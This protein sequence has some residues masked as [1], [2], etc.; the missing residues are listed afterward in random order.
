[1]LVVGAGAA[2]AVAA[3]EIARR[4]RSVVHLEEPAAAAEAAGL[5]LGTIPTGLLL[6]YSR[7]VARWGRTEAAAIWQVHREGHERLRELLAWLGRDCAYRNSGGFLLA[8]S[9][10][11]GAALAGSEDLLREDG[12]PGE[13]L[14]HYM[15]EARFDVEGFAAA[16]WSA[17]EGD[18][19]P[20]AFGRA[21]ADAVGNVARVQSGSAILE[22]ELSSRG[23]RAVTERGTV[24]AAA[25]VLAL[26]SGALRLVPGLP[27][28]L[29]V[30][31]AWRVDSRLPEGPSLPAMARVLDRGWGWRCV[32]QEVQ[33]AACGDGEPSNLSAHVAAPLDALCRWDGKVVLGPDGFPLVGLLPGRPAALVAGLADMGHAYTVTAARWAAEALVTGFDPT[34]ERFR[35]ARAWKN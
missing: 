6:P 30:V 23:V 17:D 7:A 26:D 14:D 24:A 15:F 29:R 20:R 34:P 35:A 28:R 25:A 33:A 8:T 12:F 21:L 9:R 3:L 4:G 31:P 13:F 32:A 5:D 2:A 27:E 19:D 11:D 1:V 16:Y 18:L 10:E 22:L